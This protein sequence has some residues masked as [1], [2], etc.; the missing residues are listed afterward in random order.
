[1]RA[2]H[3][4]PRGHCAGC[5]GA[6]KARMA[7]SGLLQARYRPAVSF[8]TR[9]V[10]GRLAADLASLSRAKRA[11]TPHRRSALGRDHLPHLRA[12]CAQCAR[13][14]RCREGQDGR[15]RPLTGTLPP[16]SVIAD[17]H[18]RRSPCGRPG[19]SIARKARSYESPA[20]GAPLGATIGSIFAR[21]ARNVHGC[22][23]AAKAMDGRERPPT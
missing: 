18:R 11:P 20:V 13:M 1:M 6:A 12:Q 8:L 15:E 21:N 10:G 23:G 5:T 9:I 19:V 17:P 14:H 22:T 2:N 4:A 7:G 16:C 3:S